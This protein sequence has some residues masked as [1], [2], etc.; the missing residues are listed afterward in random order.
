MV[1]FRFSLHRPVMNQKDLTSQITNQSLR[2]FLL[3]LLTTPVQ[4]LL[5]FSN[6]W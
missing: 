4:T 2:H 3:Y 1:S 5:E 6:P